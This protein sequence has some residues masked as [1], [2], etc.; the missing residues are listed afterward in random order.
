[1]SPDPDCVRLRQG[2][3]TRVVIDG[4]RSRFGITSTNVQAGT[5]HVTVL[6][7]AGLDGF[8]VAPHSVVT[9]AG[10]RWLATQVDLGGDGLARVRLQRAEPA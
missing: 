5:V 2:V 10:H 9:A 3:P 7:T 6:S 8:D 1:M 4:V